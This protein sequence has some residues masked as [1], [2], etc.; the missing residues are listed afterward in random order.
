MRGPLRVSTVDFVYEGFASVFASFVERYPD[1]ELTVADTDGVVSLLRREADVVVRL[2]NA[3]AEHL[4]GRRLLRMR[5]G[6]YAARSLAERIG[7][8][9]PLSGWPWLGWDKRSDEALFFD[10]WIARH[11][12]G[13]RVVM[14]GSTFAVIRRS[15]R[16]GVG[17]LFL[18]THIGNADSGLVSL[19]VE[20]TD[21]ARDLWALCLAELK[22]NR[23][24]RAFLDH[25]YTEFP[26]VH[27][28]TPPEP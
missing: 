13:A 25:A 5:F 12:P 14:R 23:R 3:P 15:I 26:A 20:L 6:L 17:V 4:V 24:V 27:S 16:E 19:D 8:Q 1:I 21:E 9:T 7:L 2:D 28:R 10:A 18:P 11:A 22:E